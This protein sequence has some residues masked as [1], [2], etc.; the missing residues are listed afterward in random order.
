MTCCYV[1]SYL[2][3]TRWG[4]DGELS[5]TPYCYYYCMKKPHKHV[6]KRR[7]RFGDIFKGQSPN[8]EDMIFYQKLMKK[9]KNKKHRLAKSREKGGNGPDGQIG[10]PGS[11]GEGDN[12]DVDG[13]KGKSG[14]KN[15]DGSAKKHG[16]I[17]KE[18]GE[19]EGTGI[20]NTKGS[21]ETDGDNA[22]SGISGGKEN[23]NYT[24]EGIN[25]NADGGMGDG[26]IV[27]AGGLKDQYGDAG[28]TGGWGEGA[29]GFIS[30]KDQATS[31][32]VGGAPWYPS[33]GV[34]G[35]GGNGNWVGGGISGGM[36]T[37]YGASGGLGGG[38]GGGA[39][40]W[41]TGASAGWPGTASA[42]WPGGITGGSPGGVNGSWPAGVTGGWSAGVPGGWAGGAPGGFQGAWS[43]G[44]AGTWPG[45]VQ[46]GWTGGWPGGVG[47][48]AAGMPFS[49]MGSY[50]G[51]GG[52]MG[53]AGPA[54]EWGNMYGIGGGNVCLP[55]QTRP[56][57]QICSPRPGFGNQND[58][59]VYQGIYQDGMQH[60]SR[61]NATTPQNFG[62]IR[63]PQ[64]YLPANC[65]QN[66]TSLSSPQFGQQYP[67]YNN[68]PQNC[69]LELPQRYAPMQQL[70]SFSQQY[71]PQIYGGIP[72]ASI[73]QPCN[74][75]YCNTY[76][77]HQ[78][79]PQ[80]CSAQMRSSYA[81]QY[82]QYLCNLQSMYRQCGRTPASGGMMCPPNT[83]LTGVSAPPAA[84]AHY[85]Q[86]IGDV[87][88][89]R[90]ATS[91]STNH[92]I[93]CKTCGQVII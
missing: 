28:T 22:K 58:F 57:P 23:I 48:G 53:S 31:G 65:M 4:N 73:T 38:V 10:K 71:N 89:N 12:V 91:F 85:M 61:Q 74:P 8:L 79:I 78:Q 75:Q 46:S 83:H 11:G 64:T 19:G 80:Y 60:V 27:S 5:F 49:G 9:G 25:T 32:M 45:G 87:Q 62:G 3:Y 93:K 82:N 90:C 42:G 56:C 7:S 35:T 37:G 34:V 69:Y 26:K 24:N 86:D 63:Q 15:K 81:Q 70:P 1:N 67:Q 43:G 13:N 17:G 72:G 92:L 40:G 6:T 88:C 54:S 39:G 14:G 33:N 30:G 29:Q 68:P 76:Q 44:A 18:A 77:T 20:G 41:P 36:G 21:K 59:P 55:N 52:A 66:R 84:F 16:T 2:S 47:G 51:Y 50:T